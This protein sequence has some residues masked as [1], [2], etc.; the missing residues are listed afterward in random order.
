[1]EAALGGLVIVAA[2]WLFGGITE[3][4]VSGDPL[5]QVDVVVAHWFASHATPPLTHAMLAISVIHNPIAM[6]AMVCGLGLTLVWQRKWHWF[7]TFLIAV[8]GG[9]LLNALVKEAVHRPRPRF[10]D[11]VLTLT[12]YSFTSGH[13]AAA[14]LFYGFLATYVIVHLRAWRWRVLVGLI[15]LFAVLLV[16]LSRIYLRV[17]YLS[18]VLGGMSEG[19]AWLALCLT[20]MRTSAQYSCRHLSLTPYFHRPTD[21]PRRAGS[22][23]IRGPVRVESAIHVVAMKP[24]NSLPTPF[25]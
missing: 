10:A 14:T 24:W 16:G 6:T 22:N 5:T 15:A 17:H 7:I 19:A 12:T 3:D 13:A 4:V 9:I 25:A 20:A 8:P 11:L 2:G 23:Q 1:L 21:H 18:D